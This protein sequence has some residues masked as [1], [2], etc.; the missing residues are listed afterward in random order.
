MSYDWFDAINFNFIAF[1]QKIIT[2]ATD[3]GLG[4]QRT[5]VVTFGRQVNSVEAWCIFMILLYKQRSG[6]ILQNVVYFK[7]G[8][9]FRCRWNHGGQVC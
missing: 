6:E 3:D 2:E 8:I 5:N 9:D 4:W 7:L 1:L